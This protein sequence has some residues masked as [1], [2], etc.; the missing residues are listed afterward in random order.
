MVGITRSKVIW[1]I[2][3]FYVHCYFLGGILVFSILI[4]CCLLARI[5]TAAATSYGSGSLVHVI[6]H[7]LKQKKHIISRRLHFTMICSKS[8]TLA[9]GSRTVLRMFFCCPNETHMKKILKEGLWN[10]SVKAD[11]LSTCVSLVDECRPVL[12]ARFDIA[13]GP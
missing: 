9:R 13:G 10:L 12:Q 3:S 6:S 1:Y 4:A 8:H 11:T 2:I 7:F 5:G